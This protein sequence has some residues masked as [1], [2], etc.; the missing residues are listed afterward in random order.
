[1]SLRSALY[2]GHVV[3]D[4]AR[5]KRHH[6][7]HR[8]FMLLLDLDEI[9]A[10]D[11][12]LKRFSRGRFN[13]LSFHDR[14]HQDDPT[15]SLKEAVLAKLAARGL[16]SE[17]MRISLLAMPRIL[18]K[19]FNPLSVFF[20][21]DAEGRL[22]ATIHAVRNTFGQRHDYVLP[23]TGMRAGWV[24][25]R[26]RKAF[27]VSPFMPMDL[28]YAFAI[29]PPAEA[30]HVGVDVMDDD[31]MMLSA[32]F[33]GERRELTDGAIWKALASHP[34]QVAG[35]MAAIHWEALKIVMKGF[36]FF[37]QDRA[38]RGLKRPAEPQRKGRV[39]DTDAAQV[40][41]WEEVTLR[42]NS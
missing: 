32:T 36:R 25:Q 9:E 42:R 17:D 1:M 31:G 35:V 38:E 8:V 7:R 26:A 41:R 23:V 16:A 30:V 14:D 29:K 5:P 37:P 4:R 3:H 39:G 6:L 21:H 20:C 11:A 22:V 27:Y 28:R 13:L 2:T 18:G 24:E 19:G 34:W 33:S 15:A 10:V 40:K 12:R